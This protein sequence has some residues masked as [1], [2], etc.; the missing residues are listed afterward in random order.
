MRKAQIRS[1]RNNKGSRMSLQKK[2]LVLIILDGWGYREESQSNAILAAN[3]PVMDRLWKTYPSTLISGSGLDVGLPDG[4][5][6]NSEVGHVNLGAGRIVYQD[7]TRI[8]KSIEDGEFADNPA[9]TAAID[10]AVANNKAVHLMGL[11]SPGGV[12]SH[13]EHILAA[14][15]VAAKRG[16]IKFMFTD[17]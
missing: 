15:E 12:H 2:P 4:Q 11:L 3:T 9:I 10:K 17:F 7:F 5:M 14:I 8:T 13:H 1:V 6:G 16:A